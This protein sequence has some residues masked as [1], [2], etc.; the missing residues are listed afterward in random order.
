MRRRKRRGLT[1]AEHDA[2][3]KAEGRYDEVMA[4]QRR[5]DE[6]IEREE[7]ELRETE[8]PLVVELRTAG[9]D[10]RSAWDLVNTAKPYP[11]A[12]PILVAHLGR[13]YPDR[14]REG[15][16]RALAV[17]DARFAWDKLVRLYRNEPPDTDAK[18]GLAVA[19]SAISTSAELD[20]LL[21]LVRD[22]Q[23]GGSRILLIGGISRQRSEK[24]RKA[25]A[26][27]ADDPVVGIEV[28]RL[29]KR[30]KR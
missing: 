5:V 18:D 7:A 2:Q 11:D 29:L 8:A 25:L 13:P 22:A 30:R 24:A 4:Q 14:V 1:L 23:H 27:L 10:V 16:A 19:L 20:D 6:E 17:S 3:L 28:R 15:I 26:D 12:L 21:A 9:F